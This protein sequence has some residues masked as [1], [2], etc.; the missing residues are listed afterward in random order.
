M[1]KRVHAPTIDRG[2]REVA[3]KALEFVRRFV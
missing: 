3:Y 2:W 1:P